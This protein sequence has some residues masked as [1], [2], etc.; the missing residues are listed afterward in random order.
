MTPGEHIGLYGI[1]SYFPT[2]VGIIDRMLNVLDMHPGDSILEPSAGE[3]D[4]AKFL[5]RKNLWVAEKNIALCIALVGQGFR[6]ISRDF[7]TLTH[8]FDVIIAN[9]PFSSNYQDIDHVY[10]MWDC[11]APGGRFVSL[12]HEY[13]AFTPSGN[14]RYKPN[15]FQAWMAS[16]GISRE[17]LPQGSFLQARYPTPVSVAMVW[18]TKQ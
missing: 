2:P 15:V 10:H 11:L 4:I 17:L 16:L 9:P 3:G 13:S 1:P 18:G 12:V 8:T 14:F 7:L 6:L 5:P